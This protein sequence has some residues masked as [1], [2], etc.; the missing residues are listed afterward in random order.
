LDRVFELPGGLITEDG[1]RIAAV[2]LRPLSGHEEEWLATHPGTPA[3]PA[4]T[5]LLGACLTG[6]ADA[7]ETARRLLVGD[8]DFLML[9]L[10]RITLGETVQAVLACPAC[11]AKMD[12]DFSVDDVPVERRPQAA[13]AHSLLLGDREV[14]FR[15]PTGGDQEAVLA[16]EASVAC[17]DEAAAVDALLDRCLIDTGKGAP[18]SPEERAGVIEAMEQRA[19]RIELDLDLTCPE[20]GQGFTV[21]FDTTAFFLEEMRTGLDRLLREVHLLAFYYHWGE[22]EILSLRRDRRR[23]YLALL[24]DALRQD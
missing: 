20:C 10:R 7:P 23:A 19:P 13:A 21:P 4:V 22:A 2:A 3:A 8:R 14:R 18:L 24:S 5:R 1:R 15:L 16:Y 17:D 9:Q 12:V 11:G 6:F